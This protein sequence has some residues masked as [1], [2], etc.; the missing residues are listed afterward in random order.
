MIL[1][2]IRYNINQ[3]RIHA[4]APE[5]SIQGIQ[6]LAEYYAQLQYLEK[7]FP[8]ETEDVSY[9]TDIFRSI[10]FLRGMNLGFL[11]DKS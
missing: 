1:I 8:F 2:I 5:R 4:G 10:L 3:L 9:N 7:K 6:K 11:R